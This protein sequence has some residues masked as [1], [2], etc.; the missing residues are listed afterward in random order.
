MERRLLVV[1]ALTFLVIMLFQPLLKKYGPQPPTK[2]ES[3]AE[4]GAGQ[5]SAAV[6]TQN[7]AQN[8]AQRTPDFVPKGIKVIRESAPLQATSERE[9]VIENDV[10]RIVFTNRGARVKSWLLKKYTD[11]KGGQ[12]ELVNPAAAEKYGYPLTLWSYDEA[13]RNQLNSALYVMTSSGATAPAEIAFA[14]DDGDLS[15]R[16]SYKFDRDTYVVDVRTAVYQK[17]IQ[18]TAF[19]MWPAGFGS[20]ITGPQYAIGQ[21]VY[22]FDDKVERLA[23][24]KVSGGGTLPGPLSWAGVSDQYFAAVFLPQDPRNSALV[25][26]RNPIEIRHN[27]SDRNNQQMDKV[28]V[29][30]AAVG[31]LKSP[32]DARLYVGPKALS[33]LESV[34]VPG[35]TGAQPD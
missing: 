31:S 2:T 30:G 16:K 11:D 3:A 1:F 35:I 7:S 22:Q 17:G 4:R 29:L 5:P 6:P 15:V 33:D 21:I 12:L 19:P 18:V 13:L 26:L 25:T 20:D 14:Y 32:T 28:D 8:L 10:Y 9:T 23:I 24:K 27:Q 34:S